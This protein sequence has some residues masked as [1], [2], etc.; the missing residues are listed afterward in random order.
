M[1]SQEFPWLVHLVDLEDF[2][3]V[4][5]DDLDGNFAGPGPVEGAADCRIER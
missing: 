1:V 5:V 4:V 2:V 3:A